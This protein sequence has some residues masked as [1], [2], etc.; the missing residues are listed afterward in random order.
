M[1]SIFTSSHLSITKVFNL[2][3][4]V[5]LFLKCGGVKYFLHNNKHA[6]LVNSC[7]TNLIIQLLKTHGL[8]YSPPFLSPLTMHF[9]RKWQIIYVMLGTTARE[10]EI[11]GVWSSLLKKSKMCGNYF[12][13]VRNKIECLVIILIVSEMN[14]IRCLVII[15]IMSEIN[16]LEQLVIILIMSEINNSIK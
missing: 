10:S 16:Q 1:A 12:N 6:S 7:S 2:T 13:N 15:V 14:R 5:P 11:Y 8:L 9:D 4:R 3:C